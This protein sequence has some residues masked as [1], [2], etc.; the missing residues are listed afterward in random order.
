MLLECLEPFPVGSV[1][2]FAFKIGADTIRGMAAVRRTTSGG[3]GLYVAEDRRPEQ[4]TSF[5]GCSCCAAE[6]GDALKPKELR[7]ES[8]KIPFPNFGTGYRRE[9]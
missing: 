7:S 3:M 4:I 1:V 8:S 6:I 2:R 5:S 9:M